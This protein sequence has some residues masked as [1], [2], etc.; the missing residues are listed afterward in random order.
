M[1]R[2]DNKQVTDAATRFHVKRE[3]LS[4]LIHDI[5]R[6]MGLRGDQNLT[7]SKEGSISYKG[8]YLADVKD[9][10]HYS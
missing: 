8:E 5:K 7:I 10:N 2:R 1:P 3:N 9:A 4:K 6:E